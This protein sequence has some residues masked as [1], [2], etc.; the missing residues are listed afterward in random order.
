MRIKLD[1]NLDVRTADILRAAGHDV[2]TVRDQGMRGVGD[3]GLI[4]HCRGE[5]RLLVTLDKHFA[6]VLR[7]PP[8]D[9]AGVAVLRGPNDLIPTVRALMATLVRA[10]EAEDPR[11]RLWIVEPNR[12]RIHESS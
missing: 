12:L 3:D 5:R 11:G 7:Y 10:L 8:G 4:G 1:E 2:L 9:N 6:D